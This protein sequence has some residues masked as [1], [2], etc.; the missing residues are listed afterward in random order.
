MIAIQRQNYFKGLLLSS[1]CL[2]VDPNTVG[3]IKV[4]YCLTGATRNLVFLETFY[5]DYWINLPT[6]ACS[7]NWCLYDIQPAWRSEHM[8]I[9]IFSYIM[10]VQVDE[11]RNDPLIILEPVTA[12]MGVA[13]MKATDDV[14]GKLKDLTLPLFIMHGSDDH[15]VPMAASE[16]AYNNVSSADKILEV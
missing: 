2:M 16:L 3:P 10:S 8:I 12:G 9:I 5:E 4:Q 11:Y 7:I 13:L 15:L 1:P 14:Q 6:V